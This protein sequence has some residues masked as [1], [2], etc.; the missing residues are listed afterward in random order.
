MSIDVIKE[1]L[2]KV[3][4]KTDQQS[5]AK[6]QG[7]FKAFEKQ[8][9][10]FAKTIF[11]RI[12]LGTTAVVGALTLASGAILKFGEVVAKADQKIELMAVRLFTTER[13]ARS[14]DAVMK[15]MNI[16]IEDLREVSLNPELRNQFMSLRHMTAGMEP[17][18]EIQ[19]GLQNIRQMGYEWQRLQIVAGY[20]LTY[21]AGFL[22]KHLAEPL[23]KISMTIR[24]VTNMLGKTMPDWTEKLAQVL[25]IVVK[26]TDVVWR[27][28]GALTKL[29]ILIASPLVK[30]AFTM[31]DR[32]YK[33]WEKMPGILKAVVIGLTAITAAIM[34]GGWG[35]IIAAVSALGLLADDYFTHKEGGE[36]FF[37]NMW[38]DVE[39]F[40]ITMVDCLKKIADGIS[41]LLRFLGVD[42][43]GDDNANPIQREQAAF[44]RRMMQ[45]VFGVADGEWEATTG[46]PGSPSGGLAIGK[47]V[48]LSSHMQ[49]A[50]EHLG[51]TLEGWTVTSGMEPL[52]IGSH[53]ASMRGNPNSHAS[54]NKIDL[55]GRMD[56][57]ASIA[58]AMIALMKTPGFESAMID[59]SGARYKR[60][61][62][63]AGDQI[64][65]SKF[66]QHRGASTGSH[67]D[68]KIVPPVNIY[69][70]G[71]GDPKAVGAETQ[72]AWESAMKQRNLRGAYS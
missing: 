4:W 51:R 34:S 68:A 29:I 44:N 62:Q 70:N 14:L 69:V 40:V 13:N 60:A 47:G 7:H 17:G 12:T 42:G 19:E 21:I 72:K 20:A 36:S 32:M 59:T 3:N 49:K 53:R 25:A 31:F 6:M 55:A 23:T 45:K 18:K 27:V 48:Q 33:A 71:A 57:P 30:W 10:D 35:I 2:V 56:S 66:S 11:G 9:G 39:K 16:G 22:G 5:W 15:A 64:D 37:G 58:K 26:I 41:K 54:G 1:Y 28:I 43:S 8:L 63:M 38:D 67:I 61:I 46:H 24:S 52:N 50:V 65:P